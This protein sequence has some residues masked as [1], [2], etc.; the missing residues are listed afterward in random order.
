MIRSTIEVRESSRSAPI[1]LGIN[2]ISTKISDN[3][4]FILFYLR[5]GRANIAKLLHEAYQSGKTDYLD[6]ARINEADMQR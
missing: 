2:A 5:V 3:I 4:F 6:L 1:A